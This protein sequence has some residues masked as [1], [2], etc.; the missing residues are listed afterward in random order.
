MNRYHISAGKF[1]LMSSCFHCSCVGW[2]WFYRKEWI[3]KFI[4]LVKIRCN[5]NNILK[6]STSPNGGLPPAVTVLQGESVARGPKYLS[7]KNYVTEIMTWKF[8]CTYRERC[9]IGPAHNRCW[10][11]SSFTSKHTLIRFSK[12]WNTFPK[13][14]KL[15]AWISWRI[16]SLSC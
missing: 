11:C 4:S 16:E 12:F 15:T 7:I 9:K 6:G 2:G 14:S 1:C 10:N 8:I 13:V 5:S 3:F